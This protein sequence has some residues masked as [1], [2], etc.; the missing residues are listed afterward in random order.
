MIQAQRGTLFAGKPAGSPAP[1]IVM[2]AHNA[3]ISTV[4]TTPRHPRQR[5]ASASSVKATMAGTGGEMRVPYQMKSSL[6]RCRIA[7][8]IEHRRPAVMKR[9]HCVHSH[10]YDEQQRHAC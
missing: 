8:R 4:A 9:D 3:T 1:A 5:A 2:M 10:R 6:D 7:G